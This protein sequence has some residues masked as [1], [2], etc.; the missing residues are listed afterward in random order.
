MSSTHSSR[1]SSNGSPQDD[2]IRQLIVGRAGTDWVL[3]LDRDGVINRQIIGDYVRAWD[4]FEWLPLAK[5]ALQLLSEWA[6]RLV[7]VTNQQGIGKGL[8]RIDDVDA[9]H[10]N[11]RSELSSEG[12]DIDAILVC[13]HLES[14]R[15]LCR[16]PQPGLV[17]EWLQGHPAVERALSIMVGDSQSDI[18]L[19]HHVAS[20]TGGCAGIRI[21]PRAAEGRAADATFDSLWDFA[22]AVKRNRECS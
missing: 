10:D 18:D 8:M 6:P 21:G 11:L 2:S 5:R 16:K 15:C 14:T 13:P 19:A 20:E 4:D 22:N 1:L 3:F 17:L 12:V 7:I 9:I